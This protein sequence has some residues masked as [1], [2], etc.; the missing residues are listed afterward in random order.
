MRLVRRRRD[1]DVGEVQQVGTIHS[2]LVFCWTAAGVEIAESV[3][4]LL[5]VRFALFQIATAHFA[6]HFGVG[7]MLLV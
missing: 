5:K 1:E 4:N 7:P 6:S 2:L 3:G